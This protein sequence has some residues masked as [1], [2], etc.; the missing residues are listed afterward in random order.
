MKP[1]NVERPFK[2]DN[3]EDCEFI[4]SIVNRLS[5]VICR[6]EENGRISYINGTIEQIVGEPAGSFIG[7]NWF[8][9]FCPE[10]QRNEIKAD[11]PQATGMFSET[12]ELEYTGAKDTPVIISW[13]ITKNGSGDR[14]SYVAI[15]NDMTSQYKADEEKKK[16]ESQLLESQ[17]LEAIGTLAGGI[18][19]D[20]NNIL[21]SCIGYAELC[22]DDAEDGSLLYRNLQQVLI[23]GL[24]AKELVHQILCFSRQSDHTFKEVQVS[25]I[26]KE[27]LKML[28]STLPTTIRIVHNIKSSSE[29]WCEPAQIQQVFTNLCTNAAHAMHPEGGTLTVELTDT[30][31]ELP[32]TKQFRGVKPGKFIKLKVM[33]TGQG[34]KR[35]N[36]GRIFEPFYTTKPQGEGAGLGLSVVHGVVSRLK[37]MIIPFSE[38]GEETW[39]DVYLPIAKENREIEKP[40]REPCLGGEEKILVVDDE[41]PIVELECVILEQMGYEVVGVSDSLKAIEMYKNAYPPFD[42]VITD[43]TMPNLVGTELGQRILEY[44]SNANLLLCTGFSD[45]ITEEDVKQ[46]GFKS[47]IYKPILRADIAKAIRNI[48]DN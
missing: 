28:R 32:F 23:S 15:G 29:V 12:N 14:I 34:I 3:P 21:A 20:F 11:L 42:L 9:L 35:S 18:A 47:I 26:I 31:L 1:S 24:R 40:K 45:F 27:I 16:L 2:T 33:D 5:S 17:K 37:G 41:I 44:D 13:Q 8:D 38:P 36:L 10:E 6:F 22:L 25:L 7:E 4:G 48:L 46:I 30:H 19:H 43:M 39:F